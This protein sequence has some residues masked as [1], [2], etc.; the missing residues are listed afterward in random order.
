MVI[1]F[2]HFKFAKK[3]VLVEVEFSQKQAKHSDLGLKKP[4]TKIVQPKSELIK[5]NIFAYEI[6][7]QTEITYDP[8]FDWFKL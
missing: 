8:D 7:R 2:V 3:P 1:Q 4:D 5:K 6:P